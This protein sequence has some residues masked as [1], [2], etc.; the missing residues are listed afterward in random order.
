MHSL[1]WV[2]TVLIGSEG[3]FLQGTAHITQYSIVLSVDNDS[4]NY[5]AQMYRLIFAFVVPLLPPPPPQHTHYVLVSNFNFR[6]IWLWDLDIPRENSELFANNWSDTAET[7]I[8]HCPDPDQT[9]W[10]PWSDT[11]ETLFRHCSVWS[12]SALFSY[13]PF[14]SLHTD[15]NGPRYFLWPLL[16]FS[17]MYI[18]GWWIPCS[19]AETNS[20]NGRSL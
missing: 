1:V 8:R 14:R 3:T 16:K 2:F 12:G 5:T 10:R 7:L 9:L 6:Y 15:Y 20:R 18:K 19:E 11:V 13:Y 17:Y 4:P